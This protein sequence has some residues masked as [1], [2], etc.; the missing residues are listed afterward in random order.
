MKEKTQ[1]LLSNYL[2]IKSELIS[3]GFDAEIDWQHEQSIS[4]LSESR[5]LAEFAWVVFSSGMRETVV[6]KK[7][8]FISTSFLHWVSASDICQEKQSCMEAALSV[9]NHS[10]KVRACLEAAEAIAAIGFKELRLR[11]LR[12]GVDFLRRFSFMGNATAYHLAK[13]VGLPVVKPDRHLVRLA[14]RLD[15]PSVFEMCEKISQG[16]GEPL[17]VVDLVLWRY[18]VESKGR[19]PVFDIDSEISSMGKIAA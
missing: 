8:P 7:F 14:E 4:T 10:G 2:T 13:N 11:L 3:Q 5:F 6:R 17:S 18:S 19:C 1:R 12:D 15:F 9:F 16:L